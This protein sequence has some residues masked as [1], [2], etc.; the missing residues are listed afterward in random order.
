VQATYRAI[1][2]ATLAVA[3]WLCCHTGPCKADI[4]AVCK[5]V[6]PG[7]DRILL[8]LIKRIKQTQQGNTAGKWSSLGGLLAPRLS[9]RK[10]ADA[11]D[12]L[13]WF[14][15]RAV[16]DKCQDDVVQYR[17]ER[18]RHINKDVALG[19]SL[20]GSHNRPHVNRF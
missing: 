17:I 18:S 11:T 4:K 16:S 20:E 5:D 3:Y 1:S 19:G 15:G 13:L 2:R 14:A 7:D 8:C 10:V 9:C 6:S 12:L